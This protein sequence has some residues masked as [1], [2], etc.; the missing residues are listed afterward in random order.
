[1]S[2][3]V[4]R[5]GLAIEAI[6][7]CLPLTVLFLVGGLSG[8]IYM[9]IHFSKPEALVD[10]ASGLVIFATLLCAWW[11]MATFVLRGCAKLRQLSLYWWVL[12]FVSAT[13]AVGITVYLWSASVIEPS[14][15][16]E[17]GWG[18]PFLIPLV[19]LCIERWGRSSANAADSMGV[20]P[21]ALGPGDEGKQ[22][23]QI[24]ERN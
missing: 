23:L 19:H 16:N 8:D 7:I 15:I 18:I 13:L 12:P 21:A 11:L 5:A 3:R 22:G 14:W 17:F 9:L 24:D 4:S 1:M 2:E 20:S 10:I 6:I